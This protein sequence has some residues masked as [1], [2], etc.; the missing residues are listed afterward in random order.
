MLVTEFGFFLLFCAESFI[1]LFVLIL[2]PDV[3]L[4]GLTSESKNMR[5]LLLYKTFS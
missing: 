5:P 2:W 3:V 4:G 1:F